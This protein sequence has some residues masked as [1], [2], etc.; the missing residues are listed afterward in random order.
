M[1]P[2]EEVC[3]V[4][5][6]GQVRE[7]IN[8]RQARSYTWRAIFLDCVGRVR[9]TNN[10]S[11]AGRR[12]GTTKVTSSVSV[13][14][15]PGSQHQ[16]SACPDLGSLHPRSVAPEQSGLNPASGDPTSHL[17]PGGG[18]IKLPPAITGGSRGAIP[19][20]APPKSLEGGANIS[21]GPPKTL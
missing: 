15:P 17:P 5:C 18:G 7:T 20:M 8:R 3:Y 21:F 14:V 2:G 19:A 1:V 6:E 16:R 11:Q 10:R 4:D 12:R 13:N 9:E